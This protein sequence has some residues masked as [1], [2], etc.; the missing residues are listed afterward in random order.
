V[1]EC[2]SA[3]GKYIP[4]MV[5]IRGQVILYQWFAEV[6]SELNNLLVGTSDSRYS[7]DTLFFQ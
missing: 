3:A 6:P 7:N 1:V 4:P 5:V 2:V